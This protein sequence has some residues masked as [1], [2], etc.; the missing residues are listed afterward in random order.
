MKKG[1]EEESIQCKG[2]TKSGVE[3]GK[4]IMKKEEE[5]HREDRKKK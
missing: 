5:P 2:Q 1:K 3:G 4:Q